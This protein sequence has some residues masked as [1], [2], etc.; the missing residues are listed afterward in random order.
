MRGL[1]DLLQNLGQVRQGAGLLIVALPGRVVEQ[2]V[3]V[4]GQQRQGFTQLLQAI[5]KALAVQ[6]RLTGQGDGEVCMPTV[7]DQFQREAGL[8]HLPG[9]AH[10]GVVETHELG[11]FGG[12][13]EVKLFLVGDGLLEPIHQCLEGVHQASPPNT[14]IVLNTQAGDA[15][16]TR[17][18]WLGSPL[19]QFGVPRTRDVLASPT[20]LRLRQNCA[21]IAR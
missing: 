9:L 14:S 15:W 16:P 20:A 12:I 3:R 18:T 11:R 2:Q 7:V 19:P 1:A 8:L 21:E 13:A 4:V 6:L 5:G 17:I 10:F